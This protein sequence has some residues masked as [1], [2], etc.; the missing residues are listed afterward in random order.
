MT[1]ADET[2]VIE[3]TFKHPVERVWRALT[4]DWLLAEWLM[5]N[6]FAP[7]VGH[8]FKLTTAPMPHWNGVV[9]CK[10]VEVEPMRALTYSWNTDAPDGAPGLRTL[11]RFTLQAQGDATLLRVEQSGFRADQPDNRRGATYGWQR[12][13]ERLDAA[14]EHAT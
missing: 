11:V 10:V 6:D 5:A 12:N 8:K 14:L 4:Q 7:T 13:L 3:R 2:V 9:D 1:D